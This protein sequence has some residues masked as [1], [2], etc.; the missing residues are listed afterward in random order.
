MLSLNDAEQVWL[1][2]Y[3]R[4]IDA[5]HPGKVARVAVFGSKARGDAHQYSDVDVLIIVN[6][7]SP[8]LKMSLQKI[9][10]KLAS[11]SL[12]LPGIVVYSKAQWE[13]LNRLGSD[14]H[15]TVE[16]EAIAV[17]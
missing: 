10:C 9:G 14:F 13:E 12:V 4:A 1:E 15:A 2:Q 11:T 16:R 3:R 5:H 6:D 17:A 7:D 8:Q